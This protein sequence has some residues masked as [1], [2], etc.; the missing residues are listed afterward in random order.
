ML[1]S[2]GFGLAL[3]LGAGDHGDDRVA[4]PPACVAEPPGIVCAD[5]H[6]RLGRGRLLGV[7]P[8]WWSDALGVDPDAGLA[9]ARSCD[10]GFR[11]V[12][13]R[14]GERS[15]PGTARFA[16]RLLR[17]PHAPAAAGLERM[18]AAGSHDETADCWIREALEACH[19]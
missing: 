19:R 13:L 6:A 18:L 5:E 2:I 11:A 1:L 3:T 7:S 14:E 10:H 12:R 17:H 9:R 8:A 4:P 15:T 16:L